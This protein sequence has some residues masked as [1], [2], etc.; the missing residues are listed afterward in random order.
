MRSD[1]Y[2]LGLVLYEL[3]TGKRALE[4]SSLTEMR[5]LQA[6][7]TPTTPAS[8][9]EGLDPAI[10]RAILRCLQREPAERP[11]SPLAVAAFFRVATRSPPRWP[12]ETRPHPRWW[13]TQE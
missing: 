5:R 8:H 1:V 13:P 11:A 2:G 9:V 12:P 6:E 10:E 3:F 4:A 7:S